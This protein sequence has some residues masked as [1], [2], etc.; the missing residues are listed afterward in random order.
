[1]CSSDLAALRQRESFLNSLALAVPDLI[2]V[3]D[4]ET[5]RIEYFNR[6]P[7]ELPTVAAELKSGGLL[8]ELA[9]FIHPEDLPAFCQSVGLLERLAAGHTETVEFR[10]LRNARESIWLWMHVRFTAF[11]RVAGR[12]VQR[13]LAVVRNINER[14]Q[15]DDLQRRLLGDRRELIDRMQ[16]IMDQMPIGCL[17]SDAD[18]RYTFWN[19][20]AEKL[21]G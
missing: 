17:V 16:T 18:G 10:M 3:F 12:G 14:K 6:V 13:V 9:R 8:D 5:R 21:F 1:M 7:E 2:L 15:N 19:R 11:E 4:L 20:A